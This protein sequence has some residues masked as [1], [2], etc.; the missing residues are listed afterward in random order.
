MTDLRLDVLRA[1]RQKGNETQLTRAITALCKHDPALTAQLSRAILTTAVGGGKTSASG[2]LKRIP[3][4]LMI[5]NE[6]SLGPA[7]NSRRN[8][9]GGRLDLQMVN[10]TFRLVV[11]VKVGAKV[12]VGQLE[13]YLNHPSFSNS[14][15]TGG[16]VLL[17]RNLEEIPQRVWHH[18]RWLGQIR[19]HQLI[20]RLTE[21]SPVDEAISEEW[22]L[23]LDIIQS[24]GDLSDEPI[25]WQLGGI[26]AGERNRRVLSSVRDDAR[27]AVEIELAGRRGWN[28]FEG[29][30]R[31]KPGPRARS[32]TVTGD[33][34]QLGLYVPAST[35][36][37]PA[38]KVVLAGTRK[39]LKLTTFVDPGLLPILR[40]GKTNYAEALRKL[41]EAG[42]K[43]EKDGWYAVLDRISP[44]SEAEPPQTAVWA[45]LGPRIKEIVRSGALDTHI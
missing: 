33:E 2:L 21:I 12:A 5:T 23:L 31:D 37:G 22:R 42:F 13:R 19:W 7:R 16:L 10:E 17:T 11:E 24:P 44:A 25:G 6:E 28:K 14:N 20:P 40:K 3:R 34:A 1:L 32:V 9:S 29:L 4:S 43:E 15:V 18:K 41:V 27:S 36:F 26:R 8:P 30:C 45:Q 35:K 39:P 38:I